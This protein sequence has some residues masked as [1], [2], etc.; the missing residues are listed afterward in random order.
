MLNHDMPLAAAACVYSNEQCTR[1]GSFP[2]TVETPP[3]DFP[4]P[5]NKLERSQTHSTSSKQ[6]H[7]VIPKKACSMNI[8]HA[9][10]AFNN[11]KSVAYPDACSIK[12]ISSFDKTF[13]A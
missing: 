2:L 3:S 8:T 1:P 9:S 13:L 11:N 7:K 10:N 6:S 5:S 12:F 4:S